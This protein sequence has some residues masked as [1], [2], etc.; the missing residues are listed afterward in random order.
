MWLKR[1]KLKCDVTNVTEEVLKVASPLYGTA[2]YLA[3]H[4]DHVTILE[5][6]YKHGC[7]EGTSAGD[8]INLCV[9]LS[10]AAC[11]K[12]SLG[13]L[14]L[15]KNEMDHCL[16]LAFV[17]GSSLLP[18]LLEHGAEFEDGMLSKYK[19]LVH[20]LLRNQNITNGKMAAPC[21]P[22]L[23]ML[24]DKLPV[25]K[26]KELCGNGSEIVASLISRLQRTKPVKYNEDFAAYHGDMVTCLKVLVGES[27][28]DPAHC[29]QSVADAIILSASICDADNQNR[30]EI[31][32]Y[33]LTFF[34]TLVDLGFPLVCPRSRSS[35][36]PCVL[37]LLL[38]IYTSGYWTEPM[39]RIAANEHFRRLL[40]VM[41]GQGCDPSVDDVRPV[42]MIQTMTPACYSNSQLVYDRLKTQV[43]CFYLF[44][45]YGL[46]SRLG[47][48]SGPS[49]GVTLLQD[50]LSQ[51]LVSEAS[52]LS[53]PFRPVL[54]VAAIVL[55]HADLDSVFDRKQT[56]TRTMTHFFHQIH[57]YCIR[58]QKLG[59]T[60]KV[61]CI[62][63]FLLYLLYTMN[64]SHRQ[65][66][67]EAFTK[68]A[69]TLDDD[70]TKDTPQITFNDSERRSLD[71]VKP[72]C[73][74]IIQSYSRN[75]SLLVASTVTLQNMCALVIKHRVL[76]SDLAVKRNRGYHGNHGNR[77]T[78]WECKSCST[79]D[80]WSNE[81]KGEGKVRDG[82]QGG[83]YITD[84]QLVSHSIITQHIK[85]LPLPAAFHETIS[86]QSELSDFLETLWKPPPI[87]KKYKK[88]P[89][90]GA[91]GP[92]DNR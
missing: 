13:E 57:E 10:A 56:T 41:L 79:V 65:T 28:V 60:E 51:L 73:N 66:V 29:A 88:R 24:I 15:N 80:L 14:T 92:I 4:R 26:V 61:E 1:P 39:A 42:M 27:L 77:S 53:P 78:S 3:V 43:A 12:F 49:G 25:C 48:R 18:L 19:S 87:T 44:S 36:A 83:K 20:D 6:F 91:R 37:S 55:N 70:T 32:L 31:D 16:H 52:S 68:L 54:H 38:N 40:E 84:L 59:M 72:K 45:Q 23:R 47:V 82:L 35:S 7:M 86:G 5:I 85:S 21:A 9:R 81:V 74:N 71:K 50:I 69:Q 89:S 76:T 22:V 64:V 8:V 63:N 75:A 90:G 33:H 34:M 62:T 46:G 17:L 67:S 30:T 58:L 11:L 2:L